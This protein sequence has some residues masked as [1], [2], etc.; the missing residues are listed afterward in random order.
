MTLTLFA[1]TRLVQRAGDGVR[2]ALESVRSA[3][4]H[5]LPLAALEAQRRYA[6]IAEQLQGVE[7]RGQRQRTWTDRI[8]AVITHKL[9][10]S[11]LFIAVMAAVFQSVFSWATPFMDG[12]QGLFSHLGTAVAVWLPEGA[13]TSLIVDGVIA[14]VGSVLVFLPQILILFFFVG[15]LEDSG[16]MS[17]AAFLMDRVMRF[18][19]LSGQSFIPML[20]SFACAVPGIMA[21]RV[22]ADRR[23]RF[24]TILVAPLMTCSARLPVYTVLIA[25]FIP[26]YRYLAGWI[27]LQG[28]VL[29][30][31]YLLGI[32]LAVLAAWIFK[33]TVLRGPTPTFLMELPGYK[34]PQPLAMMQRLSE[35]ARLF[36]IRAGT[37][38]FSVCVVVWALSYFPRPAAIHDRFEAE[39]RVV[40]TR[41]T[42]AALD[43]ALARVS[44]AED[45]ANLEQSFFGRLGHAIEPA[46][47]PLGWDW[48]VAMAVIASFPA[49][50]VIIS[51]LGPRTPWEGT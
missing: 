48:R 20:S 14:G 19:G 4:G 30:G 47:R 37:V 25:A 46:F 26:D 13:L 41:F 40:Q 36:V 3:L 23:D 24:A 34:W 51:V 35:R 12:I 50:E 1:E 8:D 10:G 18:S 31:L 33:R 38:I 9:W 22:I 45:A 17:R 43:A 49:R 44:A 15:V 42:G 28:L 39:Q 29:L 21:T 32:V 27:G 5:G 16:Y 7:K 6:W 11:L 2:G